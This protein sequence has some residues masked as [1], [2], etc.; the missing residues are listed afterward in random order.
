MI[1]V[2]LNS[3][4]EQ[5][6]ISYLV[7]YY[8]ES[9]Y[10]EEYAKDLLEQSKFYRQSSAQYLSMS[11]EDKFKADSL[12][13][14]VYNGF[15]SRLEVIVGD[16]YSLISD[17]LDDWYSSQDSSD[18][19]EDEDEP[20]ETD[21]DDQDYTDVIPILETPI[22][23]VAED[24]ADYMSP[25]NSNHG[26][27]YDS[28]NQE[29]I[30]KLKY[31]ITNIIKMANGEGLDESTDQDSIVETCRDWAYDFYEI[32]INVNEYEQYR[33]REWLITTKIFDDNELVELI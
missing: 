28:P 11:E 22:R 10:V 9:I 2:L 13:N 27:N 15:Q 18:D 32:M 17:L 16:V 12:S 29:K 24:F 1:G 30:E 19:D 31:R 26:I 6:R 4:S 23:I 5:T 25:A 33:M 3:P 20:Y 21:Q 7:S 8:A 14:K